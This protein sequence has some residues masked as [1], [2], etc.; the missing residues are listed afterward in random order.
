[1]GPYRVLAELGR[2]GMAIVYLAAAC[3]PSGFTKLLV[4]KIL[5]AELA[6]RQEL[7]SMFATEACIAAQLNH[8]NVAQTFDVGEHA[9]RP[10]LAMEY[11][12]GRSLAELVRNAGRRRVPLGVHLRVLTDVLSGL[13]HAHE[14]AGGLVHRDV[15]PRTSSSGGRA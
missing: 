7:V 8:P 5:R 12:E 6:W 15:S 1:M 9:G 11:V 4:V 10:Y 3:K 14:L 13:H 2:G